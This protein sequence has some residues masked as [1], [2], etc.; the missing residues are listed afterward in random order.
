[1][2]SNYTTLDISGRIPGLSADEHRCVLMEGPMKLVEKQNRVSRLFVSL[3][4]LLPM[5]SLSY[6]L[7]TYIDLSPA[8]HRLKYNGGFINMLLL[9]KITMAVVKIFIALVID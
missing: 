7:M 1:M 4:Y 5:T 9:I 2:L 3:R 6:E 8:C